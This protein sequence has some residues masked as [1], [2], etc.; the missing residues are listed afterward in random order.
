MQSRLTA[1]CMRAGERDPIREPE[2]AWLYLALSLTL[3]GSL[4]GSLSGPLSPDLLTKPMLGS[5][6]PCSAPSAAGALEH[7]ILVWGGVAITGA[8]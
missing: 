5:E 1:Q 4:S 3:S 7:F 8:F 6:G 2:R